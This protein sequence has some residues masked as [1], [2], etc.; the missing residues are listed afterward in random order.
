MT[1]TPWLMCTFN[2][3]L[4]MDNDVKSLYWHARRRQKHYGNRGLQLSTDFSFLPVIIVTS[5]NRESNEGGH[6]CGS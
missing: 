4:L 2:L 6:Y 5:E 3:V 1:T